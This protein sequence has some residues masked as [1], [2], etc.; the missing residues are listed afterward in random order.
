MARN[1]VVNMG[2]LL[3][4]N[5]EYARAL[6]RREP[7]AVEHSKRSESLNLGEPEG[8]RRPFDGTSKKWCGG[9]CPFPEGCIMCT[10]PEDPGMTRRNRG[11]K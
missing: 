9:S 7:W 6:A 2:L 10:L 5:P 4:L 11:L 1:Q 3:A 8:Y